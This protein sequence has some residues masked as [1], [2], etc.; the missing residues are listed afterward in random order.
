MSGRVGEWRVGEWGVGERESGRA[1]EGG[2]D[3]RGNPQ[4][5]IGNWTTLQ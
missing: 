2:E 4:S 1:G 3:A 5:A